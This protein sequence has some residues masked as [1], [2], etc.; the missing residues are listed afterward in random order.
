MEQLNATIKPNEELPHKNDKLIEHKKV[1]DITQQVIEEADAVEIGPSDRNEKSELLAPNG[2]VSAL[3][4][5]LHW[6]MVRTPS[7]LKWFGNWKNNAGNSSKIVDKNGEP[8]IMYHGT[9]KQDEI[10]LGRPKASETPGMLGK[11][12]YFTPFLNFARRFGEVMYFSFLNIRELDV[13]KKSRF[14]SKEDVIPTTD[15]FD[16]QPIPFIKNIRQSLF[17]PQGYGNASKLDWP[18]QFKDI[19]SAEKYAEIMVRNNEDIM[20]IPSPNIRFQ[21]E[22]GYQELQEHAQETGHNF[23]NDEQSI[24]KEKEL[25]QINE[26]RSNLDSMY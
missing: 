10:K 18:A 6:K 24:L 23:L 17:K 4:N 15:M 22:G 7:F 5:E 2:E 8:L 9:K 3:Q 11:G 20:V 12:V 13:P 16:D 21:R 19:E 14:R 26:I 1:Q 25:K